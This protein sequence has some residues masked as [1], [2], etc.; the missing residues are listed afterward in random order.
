[1]TNFYFTK[2][3][4]NMKTI[5][6]V[7]VACLGVIT[8]A[9]LISAIV[10]L[11]DVFKRIK[12]KNEVAATAPESGEEP[13]GTDKPEGDVNFSTDKLTLEQKYLKLTSEYRAYYDEI[14]RYA[15]E[16]EGH[17][18][19]KN[20]SYEEYK[21]GKN[22]VVKIKIKNGVILC[23]LLVPNLDFKNYV[24]DNKIDVRQAAT[25]IKVVDDS[26]LSAVKGSMDIVLNEI[27]KEREYKKEKALER[28]R[29]RRAM[30]KLNAAEPAAEQSGATEQ[31]T[32][33][34]MHDF[35]ES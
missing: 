1:M 23:E 9:A 8:L 26:S 32:D 13:V 31:S 10:S 20:T 35:I 29:N 34:D 28:R 17:K 4:F 22:S 25:V 30:A 12:A 15:M 14:I 2:E 16:I 27:K 24:S 5:V 7:I 21:V 6:I 18:R 11:K 19:Y 33:G 3:K